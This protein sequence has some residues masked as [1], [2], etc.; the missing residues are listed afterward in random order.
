MSSLWK[1]DSQKRGIQQRKS[2]LNMESA[3]E[4]IQ[5][6]RLLKLLLEIQIRIS[7]CNRCLV[8]N[9]E[10]VERNR[11]KFSNRNRSKFQRKLKMS[12]K[13]TSPNLLSQEDGSS[14]PGGICL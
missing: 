7:K 14:T 8:E 10:N 12:Q 4:T 11:Y 3:D 6:L 5:R 9:V 1:V 13:A 2:R